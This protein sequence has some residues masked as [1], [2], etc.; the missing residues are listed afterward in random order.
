MVISM[1]RSVNGP[2]ILQCALYAYTNVYG[3]VAVY[4]TRGYKVCTEEKTFVEGTA[5]QT[6]REVSNHNTDSNTTQTYMEM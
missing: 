4:S 6:Q 3:Y 1:F 5:S 2:V